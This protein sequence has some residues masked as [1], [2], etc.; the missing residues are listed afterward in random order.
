MNV[1]DLYSENIYSPTEE[2]QNERRFVIAIV[3]AIFIHI[4]LFIGLAMSDLLNYKHPEEIKIINV[5]IHQ[6]ESAA[7]AKSGKQS[8]QQKPSAVKQTK[9][10]K[11]TKEK[12]AAKQKQQNQD[13]IKEETPQK[14]TETKPAVAKED[15]PAETPKTETAA[16]ETPAA[17]AEIPK[18]QAITEQP[19]AAPQEQV[20]PIAPPQPD[21]FEQMTKAADSRTAANKQQWA[22]AHTKQETAETDEERAAKETIGSVTANKSTTEQ[23]TAQANQNGTPNDDNQTDEQGITDDTNNIRWSSGS[24][25]RLV[26]SGGIEPPEEIAVLGLKTSITIRFE[27]FDNG[28]IGKVEIINSTGETEWDNDIAQQFKAKYKFEQGS[29]KASG[30]IA[31]RIGY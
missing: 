6:E 29:G 11:Q 12:P 10:A 27:V 21:I 13:I 8:R 25:R 16:A 22:D 30:T 31:I 23:D 20:K 5:Q 4:G 17:A 28:L 15:A 9:P 24:S 18:P 26:S 19:T 3:L 14:Q 7:A 1:L 2:K